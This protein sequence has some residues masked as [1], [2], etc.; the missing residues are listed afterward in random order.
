VSAASVER[1]VSTT[2]APA[3]ERLHDGRS[4][5][6]DVGALHRSRTSASGSTGLHV[7]E[8]V[9]GGEQRVEPVHQVVA[10][11]QPDLARPATPARLPA[12]TSASAHPRGFTPPALLTTRTPLL[13][14]GREDA[15]HESTKSRA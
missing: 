1:P 9:A 5:D 13:D 11:H 2:S 14:A 15:L 3:A 12:S 8:L 4:A 6:V 7:R 10:G